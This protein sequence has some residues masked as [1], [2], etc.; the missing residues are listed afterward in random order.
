MKRRLPTRDV[1]IGMFVADIDRPWIQTPFMMQGFLVENVDQVRAL[2]QYCREVVIDH[3]LSIGEHHSRKVVERDAPLLGLDGVPKQHPSD[4]ES[5]VEATRFLKVA[6]SFKGKI[7][8]RRLPHVPRVRVEDGRSRLESELLYLAPIVD[9]VYRALRETRVAIDN[10]SPLDVERLDGLVGEMAS[11]VERNPDALMWLSRLKRTDQYTYDHAVNVSVHAMVFARFVGLSARQVRQLGLAGLLQDIGKIQID[12]AILSKA[13][14]LDEHE[15]E[16]V[17][18]HVRNTLK[19]LKAR[20]DFDSE[21]LGIIAA[22]HE[23][24]DGTGYPRGLE[25]LLIPLP[26]EMSGIVDTYCAM[27]RERVYRGAVSSQKA[28]ETLNQLRNTQFRDTLVDQFLQCIGLY[29]IGTLVELNSGEVGVVIQQN[30]VRR[31]QPRVLVL[32]GPDKTLERFPRTL[33][34]L[35]RPETPAGEPYRIVQ[36]LPPNAYGIDPDDLY[37]A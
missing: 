4:L 24:Y 34:L 27:T 1:K 33:D 28:M 22:H 13:G 6:R 20:E 36:A 7:H 37:L 18:A 35:M 30:Q 32:L 8:T 25:G 3:A 31:L 9:D 16:H 15:F 26:A 23:R 2:Q 19:L 21:V 17:K 5:R 12:Y 29:P 11:G 14:P 10:D